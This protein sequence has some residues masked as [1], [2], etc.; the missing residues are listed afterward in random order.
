MERLRE[1]LG[2]IDRAHLPRPGSS[3]RQNF[4][5]WYHFNVL[6]PEH[7]LDIIFNFS[8]AGDVSR[9]GAANADVIA[10]C[11]LASGGWFGGIDSYDAVAPQVATDRLLIE[12]GPNRITFSDSAYHVTWR[13]RD[14]SVALEARLSPRAEPM[15][16]WNDAPV[17]SGNLNWLIVPDLDASGHLTVAGATKPFHQVVA[18]HDHNWGHWKWGED[19]GWDWGFATAPRPIHDAPA[20]TVVFGRTASR[21]RAAIYEQTMA[22]WNNAELVK[23][24]T[25]RQVRARREG[26]YAGD[27]PRL[28]GAARLIDQGRVLNVPAH[29]Y[30][31][32]RDD[33]DWLDI[34]Y[35]I[36]SA[37]Q[38]AVPTDFGFG[39][40]D[41]NETF[42]STRIRGE[43]GG[44][45]VDFVTRACFEFMG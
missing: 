32:A 7:G 43:I 22:I 40:V 9:A 34:E 45:S 23:L 16:I 12:L 35:R 6:D 1:V 26:C 29:Y 18:Y 36:E 11:H 39:L 31:S 30:V 8:L 20:L 13:L 37:L 19:F 38:I 3:Q 24:F 2:L 5:E 33:G 14:E 44:L 25:R 27:I 15:L 17:G 42:G 21:N 28:P 41:L 4:K 10:L